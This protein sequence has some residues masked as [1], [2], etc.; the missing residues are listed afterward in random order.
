MDRSPQ[1]HQ[2]TLPWQA[3]QHKSTGQPKA[4]SATNKHTACSCSCTASALSSLPQPSYSYILA[5]QL[6]C[7]LLLLAGAA[8]AGRDKIGEFQ[9]SG[10]L[11]KDTVEVNALDDPEGVQVCTGCHAAIAYMLCNAVTVECLFFMHATLF[12]ALDDPEGVHRFSCSN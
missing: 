8:W 7:L 6:A 1:Q 4:G 9:A 2:L 5:F 12:N 3:V 10:F 11:F